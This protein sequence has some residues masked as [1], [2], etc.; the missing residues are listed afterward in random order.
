MNVIASI[1]PTFS[2][3]MLGP[4]K[5]R[6]ITALYDMPNR[7]FHHWASD[8]D[9]HLESLIEE[10]MQKESGL[11]ETAKQEETRKIKNALQKLSTNLLLD[12]Y[13]TVA[14]NSATP[15]TISNL[16]RSDYATNTN[17]LLERMMFFEE[18]DDW[19]SF[20]NEAEKLFAKSDSSMV[21]NMI[22]AMVYHIIVWS[23]SLP[24]DQRHHLMDRFKF[25][26]DSKNIFVQKIRLN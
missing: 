25:R 14:R 4:V 6:L 13:Y 12:L 15:A 11:T 20:K 24:F 9:E 5:R 1:L 10:F 17:N 21:R 2:H 18:V 8:I 26:K 22:L 3:I 23:P 7:I 19:N 16:T